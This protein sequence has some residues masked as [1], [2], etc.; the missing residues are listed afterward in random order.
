MGR[1]EQWR[2][3]E[4]HVITVTPV[5]RGVVRPLLA[6]LAIA[7]LVQLGALHWRYLHRHEAL[8]LLF[9][10]GPAFMIVV[11]R[12]WRWRSHKIHVTNQRIVVQGGVAHR[13]RTSV[14]LEDVIATRVE[15]RVRERM[16]RRGA[17][18]VETSGATMHI[19][20]VRHPAALLRVIDRE[21]APSA[22][23]RVPLNTV[24]DFDDPLTHEFALEA[25]RRRGRAQRD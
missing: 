12:T 4:V 13:F 24:F 11:T 18:M 2:E 20:R 25:R 23:D 8:A 3:G 17:V 10:V 15:Q 22:N 7:L 5:A 14:E 19:G 9:L 6:S 21:R 1:I 16:T